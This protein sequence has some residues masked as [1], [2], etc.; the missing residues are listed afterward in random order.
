[1]SKEYTEIEKSLAEY[2][3]DDWFQG[4]LCKQNCSIIEDYMSDC[5][6]WCGDIALVVGGD[7]CFK[8]ILHKT[9]D[10]WEVYETMNQGEYKLTRRYKLEDDLFSRLDR[11]Y[12]N[13]NTE[14]KWKLC[15][16][17]K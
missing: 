1:M 15:R 11:K 10:K 17:W 16:K 13:S 3:G 7:S 8:T 2:Y 4:R 12:K 9:N 5:P 14:T 6:S